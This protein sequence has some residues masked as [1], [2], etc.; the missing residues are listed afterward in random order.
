MDMTKFGHIGIETNHY[1][2][3]QAM[4]V[5]LSVLAL[6]QFMVG[7]VLWYETQGGSDGETQLHRKQV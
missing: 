5:W 1:L 7:T 2:V 4:P 6:P 3:A